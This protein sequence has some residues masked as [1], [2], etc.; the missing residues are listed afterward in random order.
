MQSAKTHWVASLI[1]LCLTVLSI[2]S[3]DLVRAQQDES[4]GLKPDQ[5]GI[6]LNPRRK[7]RA[8]TFRAKKPIR[9]NPAPAGTEYAQV[10]VIVWRVDNGRSKGVEQ[11]GEEQR[12]E[13]VDTNESYTD[14]DTIRLTIESPL[15]G[16]LYIV[17]QEQYADGSYGPAMLVFPTLKNR[18]RNFLEEWIP[19]DVPAYPAVWRFKPREPKKGE[20][21]KTQIA[22]LFT[23]IISPKP[24][25]DPGRIGSEQMTLPE[26]EFKDWKDKWEQ[27]VEQFDVEN[28]AGQIGKSKGVAQVGEDGVG[29]YQFGSQT[30]YLAAINPGT[31]IFVRLHLRFK[32]SLATGTPSD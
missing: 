7:H 16:Y 32:S 8:L 30:I 26:K 27:P 28:S 4:K 20:V 24:L 5:I 18:T 21:R 23:I 3:I 14:G 29:D 15:R 9:R 31:P 11:V 19:V 2:G 22:E 12:I 13:R 10:G 17:D 1:M 25:V 6:K